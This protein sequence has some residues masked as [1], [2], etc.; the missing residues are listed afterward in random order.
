[1][2]LS[3]IIFTIGKKYFGTIKWVL[4]KKVLYLREVYDQWNDYTGVLT[5]K[6]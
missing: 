6:I 2:V 1:M 3:F 5:L 4:K